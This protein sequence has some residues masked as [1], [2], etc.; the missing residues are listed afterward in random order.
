MRVQ[1]QEGKNAHERCYSIRADR[2][3]WSGAECNRR[4]ERRCND[5]SNAERRVP[6]ALWVLGHLTLVEGMIPAILFGDKNPAAEWQQ[7]FG[8]DSKAVAD[9]GAY[10]P[11]DEVRK[12]YL[13]LREQNLK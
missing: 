2:F 9:A 8:E 6:P 12:K 3:E 1:F 10:P 11:F 7:Y 5:V 13:Q 4:D